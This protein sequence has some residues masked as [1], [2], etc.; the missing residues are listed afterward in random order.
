VSNAPTGPVDWRG[1][2]ITPGALVIYGAPVGR[3]IAMVEARVGDPMLS[4]SGRIWLEVDRRSYGGWGDG[5]RRVH[6]GADR[7]TV[8]TELPPT[9]MPT[10]IEKH[11]AE[12]RERAAREV[13]VTA[14]HESEQH[15]GERW[16]SHQRHD[17]GVDRWGR[18]RPTWPEYVP[19]KGCTA[20][21]I[22]FGEL[23]NAGEI[24]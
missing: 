8:V 19:C 20:A 18:P 9:T 15:G 23:W 3:S 12:E 11:E 24:T 17:N 1:T 21:N 2:P 13:Y 16:G 5:K 6:V 22:R 4:P 7:L 14:A 10:E